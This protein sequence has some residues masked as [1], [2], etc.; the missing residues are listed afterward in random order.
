M[1]SVYIIS[2]MLFYYPFF[3]FFFYIYLV[4]VIPLRSRLSIKKYWFSIK[5]FLKKDFFSRFI[6]SLMDK[7]NREP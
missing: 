1:G 3:F 6:D 2:Q 4:F 7:N 5:S